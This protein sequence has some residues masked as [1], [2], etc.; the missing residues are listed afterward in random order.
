MP[1][2]WAR[3][4]T[5]MGFSRLEPVSNGTGFSLCLLFFSGLAPVR[6]CGR[7]AHALRTRVACRR[8]IQ[9]VQK[10]RRDLEHLRGCLADLGVRCGRIHNPSVHADPEYWRFYVLASSHRDFID[11]VGSWHPHK[12]GLLGARA[13]LL[14]ASLRP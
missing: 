4:L 6:R 13:S 12:R 10:D 3:F 2:R 5:T 11:L 9:L 7:S 1:S 8:Y 14:D